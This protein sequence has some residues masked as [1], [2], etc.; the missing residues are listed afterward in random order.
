MFSN[1]S[2]GEGARRVRPPP[3]NPPLYIVAVSFIGGGNRSTWK[4]KPPTCH[5]ALA[6][7]ELTTL[8]VMDTDC[9]GSF[10]SN[11]Q[12]IIIRMIRL[13]LE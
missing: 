11:Y 9:I 6:E 12:A 5:V 2:G 13:P 4:K 1:F 7:F 10:K 8:A 3:L